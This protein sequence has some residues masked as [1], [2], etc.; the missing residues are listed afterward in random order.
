MAFTRLNVTLVMNKDYGSLISGHAQ[1]PLQ[2]QSVKA[3]HRDVEHRATW[4]FGIVFGKKF[5]RRPKRSN[6]AAVSRQES[7]KCVQ[8]ASVVIDEKNCP[9]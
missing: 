2:H 8:H 9:P 5:L 6:I 1:N 3:R 7:R 4:N